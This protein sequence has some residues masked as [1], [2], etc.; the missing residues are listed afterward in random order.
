MNPDPKAAKPNPPPKK[1]KAP[2]APKTPVNPK[3]PPMV[4]AVPAMAE[5]KM[6]AIRA[7]AESNLNLAIALRGPVVNVD[8]RNV[9][10]EGHGGVA[11]AIQPEG[12]P[13]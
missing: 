10:I 11:L 13:S 6:A 3:Q 9:H 2:K 7:L 5:T 12:N 1:P 4:V 8:I